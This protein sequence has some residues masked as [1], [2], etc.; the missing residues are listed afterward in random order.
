MKALATNNNSSR[1]LSQALY[2]NRV[3]AELFFS[4]PHGT[5]IGY[6]PD[7]C[8]GFDVVGDWERGVKY[9]ISEIV[10]SINSGIA[11][12]IKRAADMLDNFDLV[13]DIGSGVSNLIELIAYPSCEHVEKI[14]Q[15]YNWDAWGSSEDYRIY[16]AHCPDN[17]SGRFK[18][19]LWP[20]GWNR[21]WT[22]DA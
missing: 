4:A 16:F 15:L 20:A 13:M 3:V 6:I 2:D 17:Y 14:G 22:A 21:I 5:T 18:P 19:N 11:D 9:D 7:A 8:R 10:Q 1:L 12:Y